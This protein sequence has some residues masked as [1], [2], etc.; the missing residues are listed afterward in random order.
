MYPFDS[1]YDSWRP[2]VRAGK[3][4]G[5]VLT[6]FLKQNG[7]WDKIQEAKA[8]ALW[9]EVTGEMVA[10]Q[11]KSAWFDAGAL[12]VA[13]KQPALKQ[14]MLYLREEVRAKI[15]KAMGEELVKEIIIR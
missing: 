3:S 6:D 7:T 8:V 4:L 11:T 15:N 1:E 10:K 12:N 2:N 14:E 5:E 9:Y 13:L